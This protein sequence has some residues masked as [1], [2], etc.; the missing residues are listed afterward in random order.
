MLYLFSPI[1]V[2]DEK[3]T[4]TNF[5]G[6]KIP[7]CGACNAHAHAWFVYCLFLEHKTMTWCSVM[8]IGYSEKLRIALKQVLATTRNVWLSR[9]DIG[10]IICPTTRQGDKIYT[11]TFSMIKSTGH[12]VKKDPCNSDT[13]TIQEGIWSSSKI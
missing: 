10:L 9:K 12:K 13:F 4:N 7:E 2:V 5:I 6:S 11:A 1:V 8:Q 3:R